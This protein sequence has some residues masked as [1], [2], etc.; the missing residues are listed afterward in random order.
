MYRLTNNGAVIRM[1]D[2]T[3]VPADPANRDYAEYLAW[4]AAGN[5]PQPYVPPT[6]PPITRFAPRDFLRRFTMAE[7]AAARQSANIAVQWA[8]D[9]LIGAQY[10]DITDP[11]TIAGLDLMV[12]EGIISA[13]KRSDLL[14]PQ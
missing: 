4:R 8:L 6:A 12:A 10:V 11:E 5:V 7:Y 13:E 1:T 14:T 9:N 3:G 2:G